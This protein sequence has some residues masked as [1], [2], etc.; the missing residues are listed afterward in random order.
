MVY[1]VFPQWL[2]QVGMKDW[3]LIHFFLS[4]PSNKL[5]IAKG[6]ASP[7]LCKGNRD[8]FE[9]HPPG[10]RLKLSHI[11]AGQTKDLVILPKSNESSMPAVKGYF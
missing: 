7:S 2:K 5:D 11:L 6:L 3:R 9:S 10:N 1:S 4:C 8:R